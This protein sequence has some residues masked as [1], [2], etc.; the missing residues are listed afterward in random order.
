MSY[1]KTT[2]IFDKI[3]VLETTIGELY[4]ACSMKWQEDRDLW[5]SLS[6]QEKA[7]AEHAKEMKQEF[8]NKNQEFIVNP[9]FSI[10]VIDSIILYIVSII[11]K[12]KKGLFTKNQML[13]IA[14]DT[15]NSLLETNYQKIATTKNQEYLKRLNILIQQTQEHK[16]LI[17]DKIIAASSL[18]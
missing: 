17:S 13:I 1:E 7:H 14:R 9:N 16:K 8:L 12:L 5:L 4:E 11:T 6:E 15:E 18:S 2:E 10:L 3:I